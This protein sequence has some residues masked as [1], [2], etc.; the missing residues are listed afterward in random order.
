MRGWAYRRLGP[1][2]YNNPEDKFDRMG[3]IQLEGNIELRFPVYKFL[4]GALFTDVG[5]IWMIKNTDGYPGGE[6]T[7]DRFYRELAMDVG[8]GIRFDFNFFILR[9][10]FAIP[11]RDPAQPEGQRWVLN[12]WQFNDV[13]INFGIGYPF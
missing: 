5:N 4:K 13:I 9:V 11:I 3:D 8:I 6:F 10:D 12:K 2:S 1:G 7:F